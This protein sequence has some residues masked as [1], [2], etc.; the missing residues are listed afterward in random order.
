MIPLIGYADRLSVRPGE[1]IS[2]HVSYTTPRPSAV[3]DD[4]ED[5]KNGNK[6][7]GVVATS[8]ASPV[9]VQVVRV[10]CADPHADDTGPGIQTEPIVLPVGDDEEEAGEQEEAAAVECIQ[11]PGPCV[12][13]LGSHAEI[14]IPPYFWRTCRGLTFVA[15]I[16]PTLHKGSMQVIA[17]CSNV[18]ELFLDDEGRLNGRFRSSTI[19]SACVKPLPLH[20]WARVWCLCNE[21][22][23][24]VMV[25]WKSLSDDESK[26]DLSAVKL[27]DS[28]SFKSCPKS[29][30]LIFA[31]RALDDDEK[32]EDN[33]HRGAEGEEEAEEGNGHQTYY[34]CHFNG[35]MEHPRFWRIPLIKEYEGERH[36]ADDVNEAFYRLSQS[37]SPDA[38][39][40]FS[41]EMSSQTIQDTKHHHLHGKLINTPTRAVRGSN[42]SG[43]E[44][45]W[46]HAK[47]EYGAIHFHETDISDCQWPVCYQWTVPANLKSG[48]YALLLEAGDNHKDNIPFFV[49]PPKGETQADLAVI[50]STF[51]YVIYGNHAR[52]EWL[53]DPQWKSAWERQ[54]QEHPGA[55]P[56]NPR[57]HP[58]YGWS[59]YNTHADGS[60]ICLASWHRPLLNVK[61]GYITFPYPDING[62]GLRHYTADTHLTAWLEK[63][64]IP[65]DIITDWELHTEGSD[66]LKPYRVVTTGTHPE[67][68]SEASLQAHFEYRNQGGRFLYLG[69]NGFYWKIAVGDNDNNH[70]VLEIRRGE[71]GVRAWASEPGEYYHQLGDGTYGGLWRRSGRA[72][73]ALTGVGFTAQGNF[74]GSY[75]KIHSGMTTNPRTAFIFEGISDDII[76]KHGLSGHGAAGFELDRIDEALGTP[77]HALV[78]ASSEGHDTDASWILVFEE[79]L[80]HLGNLAGVPDQQLIRS[81]MTFFE[82]PSGGA[83][84]STG[85]ITY[86]GSLLTND[87]KNDISRLTKNVLTKFLDPNSEFAVPE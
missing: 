87:C 42:W 79:R 36:P 49:I 72:P 2:F 63:Q 56:Y 69:G 85:S 52:G 38:E 60:G 40:D 74:V 13:Q 21:A 35:R 66:V 75:Y 84:F 18:F 62:S 8:S 16:M 48:N 54:V 55:Y 53:E 25:G 20:Q 26:R 33:C 9:K 78:V 64:K 68:H 47:D 45:C 30:P 67:Y 82:T 7:A 6:D 81:D 76:G 39:W 41:L 58:E 43:Q 23:G 70:H 34:S 5:K 50:V 3:A 22:N 51:T 80:T 73:Q 57:E 32:E 24:Q 14:P 31:A 4:D 86:C 46:R 37:I 83:V 17:S 28:L 1:T 29:A 27:D 19:V 12:T 65:Y 77:S 15:N 59:T 11:V 71:G 44:M 61:I 10:I